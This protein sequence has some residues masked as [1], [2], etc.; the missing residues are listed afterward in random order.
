MWE[1]VHL[2]PNMA[3]DESAEVDYLPVK[4]LAADSD[5]AVKYSI[6]HEDDENV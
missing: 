6:Y 3:E 4:I 1:T 5:K 2:N